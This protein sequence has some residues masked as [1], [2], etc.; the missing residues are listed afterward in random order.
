MPTLDQVAHEINGVVEGNGSLEVTHVCE[1]KS[2]DIGGITFLVDPKFKD[3]LASSPATAVIVDGDANACGKPAIR[4]KNATKGFA[5]AIAY[6]HPEK[7]IEPGIHPSAAVGGNVTVGDDI[8]VGPHVV[9]GDGSTVGNG[10]T[11]AAGAVIGANCE[12]GNNVRLDANVVLYDNSILGDQVI[13]QSNSSIGSDGYGYTTEDGIQQ[14][15]PHIGNVVLHDH[16]EIGSNVAIDRG[17]IGSTVIGEGTKIGN[18]THIAHNVKIGQHCLLT[19]Q[20]GIAGSTVVGDYVTIAGQVGIIS[21]AT[22]G[23]R[24]IIASKAA[25]MQSVPAGSFISGMPASDHK[26]WLR[27]SAAIK[28]LPEAIAQLRSLENR[29]RELE[30]EKR[31]QE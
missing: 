19:G 10:S 30:N 8:C 22:V 31:R 17:T 2:G 4:V 1:I 26:Q 27:Q 3:E 16:V 24:T 5:E 7:V 15:I 11:I 18:L 29:T 6:L 20:I 28:K 21:H 9:I 25:V 14:K 13:I 12:I 23:D